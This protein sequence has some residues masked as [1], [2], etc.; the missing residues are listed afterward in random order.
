[1]ISV[2]EVSSSQVLIDDSVIVDQQDLQVGKKFLA[3]A[4]H[5]IN[6]TKKRLQ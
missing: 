6:T 3:S 1:M 2:V 4:L 5:N